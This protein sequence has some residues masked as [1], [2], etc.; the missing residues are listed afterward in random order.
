MA[1]RGYITDGCDKDIN[2]RSRGVIDAQ[3]GQENRADIKGLFGGL[4]VI[5]VTHE[6]GVLVG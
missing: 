5:V 1:F 6:V 4:C 2:F 3:D